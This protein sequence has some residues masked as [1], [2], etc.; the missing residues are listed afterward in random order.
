MAQAAHSAVAEEAVAV[1]ARA[2][3]GITRTRA[4]AHLAQR[5]VAAM[6]RFQDGLSHREPHV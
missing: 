3:E 4:R 5:D 6:I 1:A 2:E